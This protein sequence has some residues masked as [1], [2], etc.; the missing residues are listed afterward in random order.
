MA[1][2]DPERD[3]DWRLTTWEGARRETM[4]RWAAL[5]LHRIVA[6]LE[7]MES[8]S[9]ALGGETSREHPHPE[10]GPD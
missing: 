6:A 8:V 2:A 9:R 3:I 1:G 4:R 10:G 7:E 5:P